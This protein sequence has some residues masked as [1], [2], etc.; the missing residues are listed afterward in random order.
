MSTRNDIVGP[1]QHAAKGRPCTPIVAGQKTPKIETSVYRRWRHS[2]RARGGGREAGGPFAFDNRHV[3][4]VTTEAGGGG[5]AA[6][7][8]NYKYFF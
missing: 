7:A 2:L 6:N 1:L 4:L 8:P 5:T 3:E